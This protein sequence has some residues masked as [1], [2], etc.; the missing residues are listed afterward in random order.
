[1]NQVGRFPTESEEFMKYSIYATEAKNQEGNVKGFA[2][3]VFGESFK[4]TNIAIL[5]NKEKGTFF[6]SM[7]RY[8]SS[9]R[10]E[11]GSAVYKDVCN[12]ITA[13]F[14]EELYGNILEAF[15]QEKAADK[16]QAGNARGEAEMPQFSVTVSLYERGGSNIRGLARIYFDDSFIVSNV[17]ILQGKDKVFVAMPSYKTKQ[18]DEHG[19]PVYQDVCYPVTKEFREKLYKEIL[20]AYEQERNRRQD[21]HKGRDGD[22][23]HQHA[24]NQP[25]LHESRAP[26]R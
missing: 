23:G 10:D 20:S 9:E 5:E 4:V 15:E 12:P 26:F 22:T 17:S 13:E 14:R 7:P 18:T 3:L 24:E 11:N 6:V 19:K 8:R 2:N 1:M 25:Q 21:Q 16:S